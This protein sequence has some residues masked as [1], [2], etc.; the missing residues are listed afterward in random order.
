MRSRGLR[1]QVTG[2]WPTPRGGMGLSRRQRRSLFYV[3]LKYLLSFIL[4]LGRWLNTAALQLRND[5]I[6]VFFMILSKKTNSVGF[7]STFILIY[8]VCF[9]LKK[10]KGTFCSYI[11]YEFYLF[12]VWWRLTEILDKY[13]GQS[14][15]KLW[16]TK[17]EV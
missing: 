3:M 4:A 1:T 13:H 8:W 6:H 9:K 12:L 7:L 15:K 2:R 11:F 10:N 16:D 14:G 5:L 17:H